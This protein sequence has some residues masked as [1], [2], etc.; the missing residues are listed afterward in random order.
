VIQAST[1][2]GKGSVSPRSQLND[3]AVV[4]TPEERLLAAGIV[5]PPPRA[6]IANFVGGVLEGGLLF[7]SGQGPVTPDGRATGKVGGDVGVEEA[8]RHAR[9]AGLNLLSQIQAILGSLNHVSRIVKVFGMV[10]AVDHFASHPLVI[11]GCSD[12][13]IEVFGDNGRHAR[14]AV[15]VSSL[16]GGITVEIEAIVAVDKR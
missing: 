2:T 1:A 5:L 11:N 6:P 3:A 12:L 4:A 7:L 14:S 9:V 13:F 15:G 16:P 8:Y 10:N